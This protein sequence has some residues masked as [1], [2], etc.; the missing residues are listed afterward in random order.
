MSWR[1]AAAGACRS[2]TR[3]ATCRSIRTNAFTAEDLRLLFEKMGPVGGP[4][5]CRIRAGRTVEMQLLHLLADLA[6][7]DANATRLRGRRAGIAEAA[8]CGAVERG[9]H[10]SGIVRSHPNRCAPRRPNRA[11]RRGRLSVPRSRRY[12]AS[13]EDGVRLPDVDRH[14]PGTLPTAADRRGPAGHTRVGQ[15]LARRSVF[16]VPGVGRVSAAG[17]RAAR[18]QAPVFTVADDDHWKIENPEFTFDKPLADLLKGG[19]WAMSRIY[20]D[21]PLRLNV[22]SAI[23]APWDV[24]VPPVNLDIDIPPFGKIMT[25]RGALCRRRRRAAEAGH[26]RSLFSGALDELKKTLDSLQALINLP[27]HVNVT[28]TAA[29]AGSLSFIVRIQLRFRI[30]EGPNERIDIGLGKFYGEF[31]IDGELEASPSGVRRG[32]LLAEFTGDLQ[33]GVLPPLLYAGGLFRFAVEIRDTGRPLIELTFAAVISVGGD[34]IK[35][36]LEVEVT[37]K[38]G[39]TLIPETLQ[40]GVFLGLE[41]RA[42]LLGGLVGFSFAAEVMARIARSGD[43]VTPSPSAPASASSPPCRS[44]TSSKT[45][46]ISKPSSNRTC[47]SRQSHWRSA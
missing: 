27:F 15:T 8:A 4:V 35:G 43:N 41:V 32:R 19:E 11:T 36:L 28:V 17:V 2:T 23:P 14:E 47:R 10:R 37:I 46:S 24:A 7:N 18:A 33:Q 44:R 40:P 34:L 31:R 25:I 38:Y 45:T 20:D 9:A 1:E 3:S 6:A 13:A 29:G 21:L 42:K 26:A 12:P 5:N 30:A 39:Y 22:D 16:A